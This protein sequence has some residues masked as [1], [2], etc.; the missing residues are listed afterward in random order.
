MWPVSGESVPDNKL[1]AVAASLPSKRKD[2]RRGE[3]GVVFV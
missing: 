2:R 1:R 3:M